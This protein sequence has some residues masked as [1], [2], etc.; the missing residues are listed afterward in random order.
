MGVQVE[1]FSCEVQIP[2]ARFFYGYQIAVENIHSEMYCLLID[3]YIQ[4]P[5]QRYCALLVEKDYDKY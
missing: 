2:E 1:R 3:T 4:D 5:D